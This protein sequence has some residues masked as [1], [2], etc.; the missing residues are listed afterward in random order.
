MIKISK[1][2]IAIKEF[3]NR[4]I[5]INDFKNTHKT[6]RSIIFGICIGITPL[7]GLTFVISVICSYIFRLNHIIIQS[8]QFAMSP[9]QIIL[10]YPFFK[11]VGY[12]F[13]L[14]E[15]LKEIKPSLNYIIANHKYLFDNFSKLIAATIISWIIISLIFGL[16]AY[17]ILLKYLKNKV[18]KSTQPLNINL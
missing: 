3:I 6:T 5:N 15:N 11:L 14:N 17:W 18:L 9:L 1:P 12:F 10:F 7:I 4:I 2:S 16:L 8:V 13:G